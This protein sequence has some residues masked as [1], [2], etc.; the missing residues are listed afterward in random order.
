VEKLSL[1]PGLLKECKS[2]NT[3]QNYY[4][5]FLRWRKWVLS[6]GIPSEFIL[7]AKPFHVPTVFQ[8]DFVNKGGYKTLPLTNEAKSWNKSPPF[9]GFVELVVVVTNI[10]FQS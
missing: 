8:T 9:K 4:Y 7:P 2:S 10:Y 5:V 3:V 6:N 1:I